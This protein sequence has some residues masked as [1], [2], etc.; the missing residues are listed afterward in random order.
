QGLSLDTLSA[1]MTADMEAAI[2]EGSTIV[3]VGTGIF[4]PRPKRNNMD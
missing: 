3:R 2:A 4:G 1:G